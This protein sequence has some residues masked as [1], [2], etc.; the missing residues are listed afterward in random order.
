MLRR[1]A[2]SPARRPPR[3][4]TKAGDLVLDPRHNG[5]TSELDPALVRPGLSGAE[6]MPHLGFPNSVGRRGPRARR[7]QCNGGLQAAGARAQKGW[8]E[9]AFDSDHR[10]D[11]SC[12]R[13]V[14]S[15]RRGP[16]RDDQT[17][18]DTC[19]TETQSQARK[20]DR[21]EASDH[22]SQRRSVGLTRGNRASVGHG[23]SRG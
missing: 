8:N 17:L 2:L 16:D 5:T 7:R 14:A 4:L 18:D 12:A 6:T 3:S 22:G 13:V 10:R 11:P 1:A 9:G 19:E 21:G 23:R 20:A 15:L